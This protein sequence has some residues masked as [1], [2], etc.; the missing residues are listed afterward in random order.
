MKKFILSLTAIFAASGGLVALH[1]PAYAQTELRSV[2]VDSNARNRCLRWFSINNTT[3]DVLI[4]QQRTAIGRFQVGSTLTLSLF[5]GS[6]C[7]GAAS[8]TRQIRIGS[9]TRIET[10]N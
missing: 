6:T 3:D 8:T 4:T 1:V 2:T 7:G 5:P 9:N 10:I